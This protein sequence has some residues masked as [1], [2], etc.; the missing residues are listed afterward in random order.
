[1]KRFITIFN[2]IDPRIITFLVPC[3]FFLGFDL[4]YNEEQYFGYSKAF[5]DSTWMKDS[6]LFNDFPGT[7]LLFQWITGFLLR[8][9]SFEQMGFLGRLTGFLFLSAPVAALARYFKFNNVLLAFW[10]LVLYIPQQNFFAGGWI[11]GGFE[12]KTVAYIF[13]LWSLVF[14]LRNQL[15]LSVIFA[16]ISV[17]WH[18]LVGGWYS[19]YL[20]IF[21]LPRMF[22]TR[23]IITYWF[24]TGI[25]LLPFGWYIYR[26]LLANSQAVINGVNISYVYTYIR[27][28]TISGFS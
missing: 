12:S 7:R 3:L 18:I 8:Y 6:F 27:T 22:K 2:R 1:M 5:M 15:F 4:N 26:G 20:F 19:I 23:R 28:R 14:L 21:L 9:I 25:M 10:L 16:G 17:Y 13:I 11:Y 24:I